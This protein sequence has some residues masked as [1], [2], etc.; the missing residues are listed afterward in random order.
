MKRATGLG[1]VYGYDAANQL[2]NVLYDA[3]NPDSAPS[4]PLRET[5]Y[6]FDSAGN[7]TN[8]VEVTEWSGRFGK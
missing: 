3:I 6:S 8:V 7:R 1:D 4:A 5:M 2:T